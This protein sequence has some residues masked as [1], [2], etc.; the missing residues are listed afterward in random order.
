VFLKR[1]KVLRNFLWYVVLLV[2][3]AL[4]VFTTRTVKPDLFDLID[5]ED[6]SGVD[7]FLLEHP[8]QTNARKNGI[9]A[10][11]YSIMTLKPTS[12]T[13]VVSLLKYG[14]DPNLADKDGQTPLH[15][16]ALSDK[17]QLGPFAGQGIAQSIAALLIE[18]GGDP[19][20]RNSRGE[21]AI[22]LAIQRKNR[23]LG[24]RMSELFEKAS[25]SNGQR[26]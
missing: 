8:A 16:I 12:S 19:T 6:V 25:A 2:T 15:W 18:H 3:I 13:M 17:R 7:R 9:P 10:I 20:L 24:S 22:D 5:R 14:A 11:S 23:Q 21:T 26:N 4:A 1:D